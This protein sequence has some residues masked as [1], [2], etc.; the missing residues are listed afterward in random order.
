MA[1]G[2]MQHEEKTSWADIKKTGISGSV[3]WKRAGDVI[4]VSVHVTG[5]TQNAYTTVGT[6]PQD[7]RPD[8]EIYS[9]AKTRYNANNTAIIYTD[10]SGDIQ[11]APYSDTAVYVD[12]TYII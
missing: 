2:P 4:M 10:N 9:C 6:I 3:R 11:V 12:F 8:G 1:L 7:I 5:L